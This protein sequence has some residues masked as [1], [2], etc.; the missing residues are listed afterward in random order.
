MSC[1]F[2][3]QQSNGPYY[4]LNDLG[5]RDNRSHI[6]RLFIMPS[7]Y[8][9]NQPSPTPGCCQLESWLALPQAAQ[10]STQY[11]II[12]LAAAVIKDI[13]FWFKSNLIPGRMR[14]GQSKCPGFFEKFHFRAQGNI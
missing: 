1:S 5:S 7:W 10:L 3:A 2:L 6:P 8:L 13:S 14:L 12:P 11:L 4:V 9:K